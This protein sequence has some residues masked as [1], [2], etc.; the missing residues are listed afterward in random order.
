MN[1]NLAEDNKATRFSSTRRPKNKVGRKPSKWKAWTKQYN[2]PAEDQRNVAVMILAIKTKKD[3]MDMLARDDIPFG[4]WAAGMAALKD[5]AKGGGGFLTKLYEMAF[6]KIPDKLIT[7]T[8]DLTQLTAEER[9][10]EIERLYQE[11]RNS[12]RGR[13]DPTPGPAEGAPGELKKTDE[14]KSGAPEKKDS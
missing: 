11:H 2:V 8:E 7:L 3:L 10:A 12:M 13:G 1:P 4:V 6:G 5:A 9:Y 14:S